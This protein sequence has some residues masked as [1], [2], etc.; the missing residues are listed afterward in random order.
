MEALKGLPSRDLYHEAQRK[1][2]DDYAALTVSSMAA[3]C[4][5]LAWVSIVSD[6]LTDREIDVLGFERAG[7][8]QEALQQA[9][10]RQGDD[11][12]IAVL[13]HG[14][15]TVPVLTKGSD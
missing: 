5:E 6:G 9:L 10:Q 3:C 15:E 1:G 14:G 2:L 12:S 8:V 4:R 11:A 13:T 7:S